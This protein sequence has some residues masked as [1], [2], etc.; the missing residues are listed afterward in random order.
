VAAD[1]HHVASRDRIENRSPMTQAAYDDELAPVLGPPGDPD[2]GDGRRARRYPDLSGGD[3]G[4]QPAGAE[5]GTEP[6]DRWRRGSPPVALRSGRSASPCWRL[7]R[8]RP[9]R[10]RRGGRRRARRGRSRR[11]GPGSCA[12]LSLHK[13]PVSVI[14]SYSRHAGRWRRDRARLIMA[15]RHG[16]SPGFPPD[17]TALSDGSTP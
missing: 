12:D 9:G 8:W 10:P 5:F 7:P 16:V 1:Q 17:S 4:H 2:G 14:Y 13:R 15:A 6:I 3:R 11:R